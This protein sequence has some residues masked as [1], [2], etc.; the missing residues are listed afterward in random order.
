MNFTVY[1]PEDGAILRTGTASTRAT[2]K[3]QAREGEAVILGEA[4]DKA[5]QKIIAGKVVDRPASELPVARQEAVP[6]LEEAKERA[7]IVLMAR[8]GSIVAAGGLAA[9]GD[10]IEA[11]RSAKDVSEVRAASDARPT[12]IRREQSGG[13]YLEGLKLRP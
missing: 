10:A 13:D 3:L 9:L 7:C 11:V 5:T 6:T 2:A 12:G 4:A 1:R 8:A